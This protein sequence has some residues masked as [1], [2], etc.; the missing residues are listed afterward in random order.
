MGLLPTGPIDRLMGN[1]RE[2]DDPLTP[3]KLW[4]AKIADLKTFKDDKNFGPGPGSPNS[5]WGG[6]AEQEKSA[7]PQGWAGLMV[8]AKSLCVF[9]R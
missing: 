7:K 2:V 3:P 4:D 5:G 6:R 8:S 9:A 1:V